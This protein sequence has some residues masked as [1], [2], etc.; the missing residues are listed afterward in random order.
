MYQMEYP[1]VEVPYPT[2]E[3]SFPPSRHRGLTFIIPKR[4]AAHPVLWGGGISLWD[5]NRFQPQ[6]LS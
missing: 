4:L 5:S 2:S 3:V 1:L 6:R